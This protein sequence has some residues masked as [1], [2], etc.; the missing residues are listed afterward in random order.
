V[1]QFLDFCRSQGV[2]GPDQV[3]RQ[4][5]WLW[6]KSLPGASSTTLR[7]RYYAIRLFWSLL[8]RAGDPPRPRGS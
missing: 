7:D 5:V 8:G 6:Y 4:H 1:R 3:G 2:L